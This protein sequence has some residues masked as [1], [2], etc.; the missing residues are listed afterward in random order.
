MDNQIVMEGIVLKQYP[1]DG[2]YYISECG[3]I[4]SSIKKIW[5][6]ANISR[7]GYAQINILNPRT[8]RAFSAVHRIIAY[9]WIGNPPEDKQEINHKDGDKLNNHASNLEWCS[10][11]QNVKHGFDSGLFNSKREA[12]S[13]NNRKLWAEGKKQK[14]ID[15]AAFKK[16]NKH[17]F[18]Q[19]VPQK[20]IQISTGKVFNSKY[21][22][23]KLL[24]IP[25]STMNSIL[26]GS[27]KKI[28][29]KFYTP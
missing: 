26:K 24:N 18:E 22:A 2:R 1:Y 16:K 11:S 10:R 20:V 19:S 14:M 3:K 12:I 8:N 5:M 21:E 13:E 6:T 9:T 29:Y 27:Y 25:I 4:W 17:L 23:C 7:L 28:D 15:A